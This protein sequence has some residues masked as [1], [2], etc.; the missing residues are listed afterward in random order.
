MTIELYESISRIARHEAE[1]FALAAV[2]KV[3]ATFPASAGSTPADHAVTVQLR[4]SG[5]IL[6]R[7][8]IAVGLMGFAAL[9]ALDDLVLLVFMHGDYNA[10]VVVGR[11]YN[12]GQDPPEHGT[13]NIVLRLPSPAGDKLN[14]EVAG[15]T[16]TINLTMGRDV[17]IAV[18]DQQIQL[19]AGQVALTVT[20][21]GGGRAEISAGGSKIVLK[22]DGDVAIESA[23]KL[24]L[25]APEIEIAGQAK[26]KVSGAQVEI[27]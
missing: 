13:D 23:T 21:A 11:L 2:G 22:Q 7:V 3:T 6:P 15:Q 24:S 18:D 14:L 9:P 10:P 1:R 8:P 19:Q 20:S 26:V 16:P 12:A 4:D 27:N 5:L 25:K 17:T